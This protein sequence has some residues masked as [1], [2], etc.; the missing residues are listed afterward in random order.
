MMTD[1]PDIGD[2]SEINIRFERKSDGTGCDSYPKAISMTRMLDTCI[3]ENTRKL[4]EVLRHQNVRKILDTTLVTT[5]VGGDLLVSIGGLH[6][7]QVQ[8]VN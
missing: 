1:H 3:T 7:G 6:I 4:T 5:F 2:D 8:R